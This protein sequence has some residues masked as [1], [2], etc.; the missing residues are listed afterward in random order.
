ML[1]KE[2]IKRYK[3]ETI[4]FSCH[5]EIRLNQ[6]NLNKDFIIKNCWILII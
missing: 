4:E 1:F 6:R 2:L 3:K 5:A